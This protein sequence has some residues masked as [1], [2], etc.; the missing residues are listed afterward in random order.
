MECAKTSR[1]EKIFV[2]EAI[3]GMEWFTMAH[4]VR[5]RSER[6]KNHYNVAPLLPTSYDTNRIPGATFG[7]CVARARAR[8]WMRQCRSGLSPARADAQ[9]NKRLK[10]D[11]SAN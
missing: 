3:N 10:T 5:Q 2:C 9:Q 8:N 6:M 4:F 11:S 7:V 1:D